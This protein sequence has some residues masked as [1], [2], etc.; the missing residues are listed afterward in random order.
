LFG[1]ELKFP[2]F[3]TVLNEHR[4][5]GSLWGNFN[6]LRE[7]IGLAKGGILKHQIQTFSLSEINEAIDLLHAGN[8]DGRAVILP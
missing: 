8:I 1:K 7:V 5:Y 2:L 3:Q 4:I 6:E